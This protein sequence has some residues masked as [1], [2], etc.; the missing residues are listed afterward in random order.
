[1]LFRSGWRRDL[2][3]DC[4]Q[5]AEDPNQGRFL[6]G[7]A[8]LTGMDTGEREGEELECMQTNVSFGVRGVETGDRGTRVKRFWVFFP[9][10]KWAEVGC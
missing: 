4:A 2:A 6:E 7:G 1:M 9:S 5:V 8:S 3:F 10:S